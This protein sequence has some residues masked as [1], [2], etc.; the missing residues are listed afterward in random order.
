MRNLTIQ[1]PMLRAA[2]VLLLGAGTA[3]AQ[4][5]A[6]PATQPAAPGPTAPT[7]GTLDFGFRGTDADVDE[8]RYERYRD[9]RTGAASR[10]TF[11]KETTS[12]AVDAG[13]FNLGYHD[14][15][16][17]LTYDRRRTSVSFDWDS[18]PTNF[19]YLSYSPWTV[20]DDGVLTLAPAARQQV[21]NRAAV[22]V[23]CAPGGPPATCNS[24]TTAAQALANRSIYNTNLP[25]FDL[26]Q[27][28]DTASLGLAFDATPNLGINVR[29]S[30]VGKSGHQPWGASFAFN[31]ANEVPLPIDNRTNDVQAGLEWANTKGM[32]GFS[33]MGSFFSNGLSS[34]TWDNP[35]RATDFSNG[36][37]PPN[38]PYDPSGYSNGNGPAQG[39][40][41]AWPDNSQ[42]V[43]GGTAMYKLARRTTINGALQ[44]TRQ[45][46]DDALIP[47]TSNTL[48][49][50]TPSVL[51]AFPHLARLPRAT[52]EA[53]VQGVN[54]LVNLNAR[55]GRNLGITVRYR[56]NDRNNET[57][58][59]DATEYVRFDAV[60][61]EIEEGVSH[62]FDVQ[63]QTFDANLSYSLSQWGALRAG[64][65]RDQYDRHGRGFSEV[66][67]NVFRV[68]Y[69]TFATEYVSL[70][71]AYDYGARR[72]SGYIES[73]V[74]YE[75]PGGTQ[76][77]LRYYDEADRN[78]HRGSLTLTLTPVETVGVSVTYAGGS[79]DFD[80]AD[81]PCDDLLRCERFGLL[82][83]ENRAFTV[84][85]DFT[86]R[87]T[88]GLG[89]YYG[90]EKYSAL[91]MS[92]NA[93]PP[94]DPSWFDPTRNWSMDNGEAVNTLNVYLDLRRALPKTDLRFGLDLMDSSNAL[95]FGGP[96]ID[97]LNT[98]T[99]VTGS[100]PCP[101]G[102][103]DCFVPLPD[104]DTRWMR[105]TADVRYYFADRVGVGVS[106]WYEDLD[107]FDF[108]TIDGNGSVAFT[109]AT[110]TARIDYL[111]GLISGYGPR[112][113]QG[114][115]TFVRLLY[116]F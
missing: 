33:W 50:N 99:T 60:P 5:P 64:Y 113:Y 107:S 43:F 49:L 3:L 2:A 1:A 106:L 116:Q 21:Q 104:V 114:V 86:P 115:T 111:G 95:V 30:S 58:P 8:A 90:Y 31:N 35:I 19:S 80:L 70:R 26:Q 105:F 102:V 29:L 112:P 37:A 63:R 9:L 17:A 12:Y 53:E 109:A 23:P 97:Q 7:L 92:R 42:Q 18:I 40:M 59:F 91:Q 47:W 74:D 34:L 11:A 51:A 75:G 94:P 52:A 73:H 82:S 55:P 66:G 96:R 69:D 10:F 78:R 108:S 83:A 84:G 22:G 67:E 44:F 68:S 71:A 72:G 62:Q 24:P 100:A 79:D 93:N 4:T 54:A 16:Y 6:S 13:A 48:I 46:Q 89:A 76:P 103:T 81:E 36:L 38:G 85:L 87:D 56:F 88:V 110:G 65:S 45:H 14:Q 20:G 25:A 41:A 57:T 39:R 15:E 98:N 28:R 27:R 32:V 101:A 77:G 61:E